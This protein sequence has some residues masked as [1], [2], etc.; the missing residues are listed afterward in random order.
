MEAIESG[1]VK[2]PRVLIDDDS[3]R[4]ETVWRRL[5][6]NTEPKRLSRLDG[7]P[8]PLNGALEAVVADWKRTFGVWREGGQPTPPVLIIVA[9]NISNAQA[10]FD[11]IAGGE[12]LDGTPR[13]GAFRELSNVDG[14]GRWYASPRTLIVHSKFGQEDTIPPAL[15]RR[16][17]ATAGMTQKDAEAAVRTMLNTVG[18]QDREGAQ[19]RCVV[20][21]S[22]LTEGWDARTVTHIVG[23]RAFSTQLLCEQVTGRALRRTAYDSF[24]SADLDGRRRLTAE[25]ADVVGIPFE[26]MPAADTPTPEPPTPKPRTRVYSVEGRERLRMVW[27]QVAEYLTRVEQV[28][29]RLNPDRVAPFELADPWHPTMTVVSGVAGEEEIIGADPS[30]GIQRTAHLRVAAHLVRRLETEEASDVAGAGRIALFRSAYRACGTGRPIPK[31]AAIPTIRRLPPPRYS[32][33]S[34][35]VSWTAANSAASRHAASPAWPDP[36][37]CWTPAGSISK[38]TLEHIYEAGRSELSHAA[39]HSNNPEVIVAGL[40]DQ[41]CN[42]ANPQ[43]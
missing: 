34:A 43:E 6:R 17:A 20:S 27:P 18:K 7:L 36:S 4:D 38:T 2:V 5:Y 39:C 41:Q 9:N 16:V 31:S 35:A 1:L 14:N 37:A 19:V 23:F 25:Y 32:K 40:L 30:P 12:N 24:Q 13:M 8:E 15:K 21:V 29:F 33:K 28:R 3:S 42:A 11:H 22:M 26:F 10:I